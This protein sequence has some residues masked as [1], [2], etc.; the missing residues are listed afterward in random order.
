MSTSDTNLLIES[1]TLPRSPGGES[2]GTAPIEG[3]Y[4]EED[5]FN[6]KIKAKKFGEEMVDHEAGTPIGQAGFVSSAIN[7]LKTIIGAGKKT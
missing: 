5:A 4:I 1:R 6:E 3:R 2:S 7:L